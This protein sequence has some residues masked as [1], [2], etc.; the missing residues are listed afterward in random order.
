MLSIQFFFDITREEYPLTYCKFDSAVKGCWAPHQHISAAFAA[1]ILHCLCLVVPSRGLCEA[2]WSGSLPSISDATE[3]RGKRVACQVHNTRFQGPREDEVGS[4]KYKTQTASKT[5]RK[6]E[7]KHVDERFVRVV[8]WQILFGSAIS[9]HL[10]A[11]SWNSNWNLGW[12]KWTHFHLNLSPPEPLWPHYPCENRRSLSVCSYCTSGKS[13]C[14]FFFG[15][16][17]QDLIL[18]AAAGSSSV[19]IQAVSCFFFFF[20][21]QTG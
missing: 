18:A 8:K 20:V 12:L 7:T 16:K 1:G 19:L 9:E 2:P 10:S 6:G 13:Q 21:T 17:L 3:I 5:Q 15:A 14:S 11:Q 4:P